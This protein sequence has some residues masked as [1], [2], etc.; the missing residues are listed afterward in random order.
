MHRQAFF[1]TTSTRVPFTDHDPSHTSNRLTRQIPTPI[2]VGARGRFVSA[3]TGEAVVMRGANWFG[4]NVGAYNFD[5]LWVSVVMT[6]RDRSAAG[7]ESTAPSLT[8][9]HTTHHDT[10]QAYCD[11]NY[12]ASQPPCQQDGD[13]PPHYPD[14]AIGPEGIQMLGG[15]NFWGKRTMTNDFATVVYRM[16]LLGFNTIRIPFR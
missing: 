4:W 16:K 12:T 7:R 5:G 11:D 13:I 9:T 3:K 14:P 15:I 2:K 8:R 10:N 1:T 6:G